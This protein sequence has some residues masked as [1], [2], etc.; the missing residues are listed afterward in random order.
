MKSLRRILPA[1]LLAIAA[2]TFGACATCHKVSAKSSTPCCSSDGG[3]S[4]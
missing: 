2:L 3:C 4:K 1:V